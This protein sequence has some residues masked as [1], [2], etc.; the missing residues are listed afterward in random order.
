MWLQHNEASPHFAKKENRRGEQKFKPTNQKTKKNSG[1]KNEQALKIEKLENEK[2]P[3]HLRHREEKEGK[4]YNPE[5]E[6]SKRNHK[7][8]RGI[9][10][11]QRDRLHA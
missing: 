1:Y 6:A 9:K 11:E 8:N 3:D 7:A 10:R 4:P 2:K 5:S